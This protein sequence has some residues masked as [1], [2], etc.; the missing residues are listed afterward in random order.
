MSCER[1][2]NHP[3]SQ[4]D[5]CA[6]LDSVTHFSPIYSWDVGYVSNTIMYCFRCDFHAV[7]R[8]VL[9]WT[10]CPNCGRKIEKEKT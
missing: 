10:F 2:D 7:T 3:D 9:K 6:K 8:D 1:C 4:C 5:F